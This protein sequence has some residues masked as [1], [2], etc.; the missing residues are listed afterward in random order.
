MY[1]KV[2]YEEAA[3]LFARGRRI[4]DDIKWGTCFC[5]LKPVRSRK[6]RT[7]RALTRKMRRWDWNDGLYIYRKA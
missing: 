6:A 1:I 5:A 3:R 4:Y 7:M 2:T